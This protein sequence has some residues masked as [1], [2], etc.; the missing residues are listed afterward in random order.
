MPKITESA[1]EETAITWF[2]ELGYAY[3]PAITGDGLERESHKHVVLEGVAS[4]FGKNLQ[5]LPT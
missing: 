1:V 2:E 5:G 3:G 4:E